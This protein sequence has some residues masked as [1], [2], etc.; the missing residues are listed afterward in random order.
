MAGPAERLRI[1][2][3]AGGVALDAVY[4]PGPSAAAVVAPP[5][6]LYGGRMDN[7]VVTEIVAGLGVA[8]S[9]SLRFDWR[10]VGRSEGTPS[11][12][13][14]AACADYAAAL[15]GL[16]ARHPGPYL[17]TG[18][19]FG[20]VT[21]LAVASLDPHLARLV[22]VSPPVGMTPL[23]R[24][25]GFDRDILVVVGGEDDLAP[26]DRVRASFAAMPRARIEIIDGADHFFALDGL[27][28]IGPLVA[29]WVYD[30]PVVA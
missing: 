6:P 25:A 8:R 15:A 28:R 24:F 17:G 22:L 29:R 13:L 19:S 7:P 16:A 26:L 2:P 18:Y 23:D 11:G 21:A 1:E 20:A 30:R 12:D 14:D 10:G 4:V 27:D 5:H 9:A 3:L